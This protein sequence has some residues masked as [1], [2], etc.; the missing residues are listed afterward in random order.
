MTT[1]ERYDGYKV[2]EDIRVR[3]DAIITRFVINGLCD[4]MYIANV[5]AYRTGCG[6]G[7][8]TF[9]TSPN[10]TPYQ[11]DTLARELQGEY[12]CNIFKEDID[13]LSD[14]LR[15]GKL[16]KD[17]LAGLKRFVEKLKSQNASCDVLRRIY[18]ERQIEE[19][20]ESIK[21]LSNLFAA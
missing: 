5:I 1:K 18:N 19:A 4:P 8:G 2:P 12:G 21:I 16:S 11:C 6:D 13:E 3:T 15:T 20:K 7:A 10:F 17:S 14:I 9:Y